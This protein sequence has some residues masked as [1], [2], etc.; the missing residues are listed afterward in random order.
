M[1]VVLTRLVRLFG[2]RERRQ[3]L[4]GGTWDGRER[5][6]NIAHLPVIESTAPDL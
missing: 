3:W 5:T 2:A 1:A 4:D 6:G